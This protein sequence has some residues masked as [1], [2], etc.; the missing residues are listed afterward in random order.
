MGSGVIPD[1][2]QMPASK[3]RAMEKENHEST[4]NENTKNEIKA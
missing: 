3:A 1:I 4:K 2:W